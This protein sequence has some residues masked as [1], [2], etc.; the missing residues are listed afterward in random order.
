MMAHHE[1][2]SVSKSQRHHKVPKTRVT[3]LVIYYL[4]NVF[5]SNM[6]S[7]QTQHLCC[8]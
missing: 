8:I 4:N 7:V 3:S 5:D 1:A 6:E 2:G